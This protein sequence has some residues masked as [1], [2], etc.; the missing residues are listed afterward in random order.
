[1]S[2][3]IVASELDEST[4]QPEGGA[5]AEY[6]S[7]VEARSV[8][9]SR[10]E[11]LD[12]RIADARLGVF[13]LAMLVAWGAWKWER[14]SV[15]WAVGPLVGYGVLVV[16]H[17]RNRRNLARRRKSVA[18]YETGLRRLDGSWPGTGNTGARFLSEDHLYA[19][20]LDLFGKGSLFER[21][22]EARTRAGEDTLARWLLG[23][24]DPPT[25]RERHQALIELRPRLDLREDLELIGS[26]VREGIDP[27][28]LA[29]W[30]REPRVFRGRLMKPLGYVLA[31]LA[32]L[33]V[34]GFLLWEGGRPPLLAMV[35][36][37]IGYWLAVKRR[38]R[39]VL[40]P[41]QK[42][43]HDLV[44]LA[45]LLARLENEPSESQALRR[46]RE[47]LRS[48]CEPASQRIGR[49][50]KLLHLLDTKDNQFFAP[51]AG[52]LLWVP[53]LAFRID[54]W[55]ARNGPEIAGWLD[56]VGE[57]EALTSLSA[58][59]FEN[60]DDPFPEIVEDDTC[61]EAKAVGHPLLPRET[62]VANDVSLG[63][64][65]RVL[66]MSGSNMSGKS[67]MLR[68]VGVNTV[69][70]LAGGPV[71]ATSLRLSV[72]AIGATLRIQD[73]LQAG[74]SRFYA[75]ITRVKD[76]VGKADG[77][78]PL[79]FLLDEIFHG[80]N[81]GD[82]VI[83]AR[84]VVSGLIDRGAIGLVT[85]HDLALAEV[86]N[87]LAPRALNVHFEDQ[88]VDGTMRFDYRMRPGVVSHSNALALM[89]AVGLDV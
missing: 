31:S 46:L 87:L 66:L 63:G 28:A 34:F 12:R 22:C 68:T 56:A 36:L 82:R 24:A 80:T 65:L 10:L 60:P 7:R 30:G 14:F 59:S 42:R 4:P 1:M 50:A 47:S 21:L 58:Y 70:A 57:F 29:A 44:I 89:R 2:R 75:E 13:T 25:I 5:R 74:R 43:T 15:V 16:W 52:L 62:C 38:V 71:R 55:R 72:L 61:F 78:L 77:P 84:G 11:R 20:D 85:T 6:Q 54:D 88:L 64:D 35:F 45:E 67:T 79:L 33:A 51:I 41:I 8:D 9:V 48:E 53:Q 39:K 3:G 69:L 86:A 19:A 18:F 26:E 27:D 17:D 83:G 32:I 76:L 81:S 40:D 23:P 73:S 37:E 49:L